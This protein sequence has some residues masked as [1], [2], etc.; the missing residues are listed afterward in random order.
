MEAAIFHGGLPFVMD[1]V[2]VSRGGR[3]MLDSFRARML[4][5]EDWESDARSLGF[6]I[7]KKLSGYPSLWVKSLEPNSEA[8]SVISVDVFGE[9]L[10][11]VGDRRQRK[12]QCG[13]QETSVGPT[14]KVVVV[15][16][17]EERG[18]DPKTGG[19]IDKVKKRQAELDEEGEVVYNVINT[20]SGNMNSWVVSEAEVSVVD[21]YYTTTKPVMNVVGTVVVPPN[22]PDVPAYQWGGYDKELRGRH[23][24]GWVL[25]D[26]DVDELFYYSDSIG[27]WR[28]TDTTT[29]KH[30]AFPA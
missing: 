23:P 9:G 26:R 30:P 17:K 22:P 24:N 13:E 8:E 28:V 27:L 20:P 3:G 29:F 14:E 18:E 15:W 6:E 11:T 10:G 4:C 1:S 5:S 25:A 21:T 16:S 12:M 7:D 19:K 2:S